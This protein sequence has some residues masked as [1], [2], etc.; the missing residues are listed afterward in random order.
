MNAKLYEILAICTSFIIIICAT[1]LFFK[2]KKLENSKLKLN[3][4]ILSIIILFSGI[5]SVLM[6]SYRY[7][8]DKC[9]LFCNHPLFYIDILFAFLSLAVLLSSSICTN[10]KYFVILAFIFM[11]A[12]ALIPKFDYNICAFYLHLGGHIIICLSLIYMLFT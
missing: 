1:L 4:I 2:F 3:F 11:I 8:N 7:V 12:G 10:I 9:G 6:R 5:F